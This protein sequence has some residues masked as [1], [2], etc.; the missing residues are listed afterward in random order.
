MAACPANKRENCQKR[1]RQQ[2]EA[3]EKGGKKATKKVV[4]GTKK[5]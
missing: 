1:R 4:A 3:Y 5:V 2:T